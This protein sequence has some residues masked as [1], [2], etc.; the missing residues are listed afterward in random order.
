MRNV[1]YCNIRDSIIGKN[2]HRNI[3]KSSLRKRKT[4][5]MLPSIAGCNVYYCAVSVFIALPSAALAARTR[6]C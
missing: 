3:S 4:F 1:R 2:E 5:F 6:S